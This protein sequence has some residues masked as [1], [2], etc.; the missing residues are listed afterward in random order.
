M[1]SG[2]KPWGSLAILCLVPFV[3]VLGNSMLIPVLPEI[4]RVWGVDKSAAGLVVTMFSV[5]AGLG[6]AVA[7]Y[8]ADR[9][10]RKVVMVPA[11]ALY[12]AGG[13]VSGLAGLW[14]A[15]SSMMPVLIGRVL[16]GLG[17]AGTM[18]VAMALVGDLFQDSSRVTALGI[19]EAAN[20]LGKVVSPILGALAGLI[21]W[22]FPFFGYTAV[23]FPAAAAVWFW[24]SEPKQ[25]RKKA[26][27]GEYFAQIKDVFVTKGIPLLACFWAGT[28][29]LFILFGILFYLSQYLETEYGIDGVPKGFLIMWPVLAM[30]VTAFAT[31]IYLQKH[32]HLLKPA[33]VAGF[34]LGLAGT[35]LVAVYQT[36]W[37]LFTGII[38]N[39]IG[40]GLVLPGL[41]NLITSSTGTD[42]RAGVTAVY[43]AV[44]FFGV[45][46]GPPLYGMLMKMSDAAPFWFSAIVEAVT[47][48]VAIFLIN[49]KRL[50]GG[51]K[52]GDG[53]PKGKGKEVD[54][55]KVPEG[56][57]E[58][59]RKRLH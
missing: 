39:G 32:K 20:G 47:L 53:A 15:E 1:A 44:R 27:L 11:L 36:Y 52:G 49:P 51:E 8:L 46:A 18:S 19:L 6:I 7:G 10:G 58:G 3:M 43:G 24:V 50:A 56:L 21:G 9:F 4:G 30:S 16:Q 55:W 14:L 34:I 33:V 42:Q 37:T 22:W 2:G 23:A 17:A 26:P 57:P 35:A 54:A 5:A 29:A 38:I 28:V 59:T 40:T 13:I 31:G 41:N 48:A 45:A 12:G 25:Q